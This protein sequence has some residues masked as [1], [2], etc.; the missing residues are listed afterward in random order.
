MKHY[1]V[2]KFDSKKRNADGTY[3]DQQEWTC[4]G[5]I[6]KKCGSMVLTP[7]V[8]LRTEAAYVNAVLRSFEASGLPHLRVTNL[9]MRHT[10]D[11]LAEQEAEFPFLDTANLASLDFVE[12][13]TVGPD[14]IALLV[15]QN[16]R[17]T[18]G[19][20]LEFEGNFFVHFG[21]DYYMYIGCT[22]NDEMA[23]AETEHDGLFVEEFISP[24]ARPTG[25][26]IPMKIEV[27]DRSVDF[28]LIDG[29]PQ[30]YVGSELLIPID[31]WRQVRAAFGYSE[32]HP[33]FGFYHVNAKV[34]QNLIEGFDLPLDLEGCE[35]TVNT[36][37]I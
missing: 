15:V 30:Y 12:D 17:G 34:G 18:L 36:T 2:T 23:R 5:E 9:S 4:I 33:F 19:C 21:W 7:Q 28:D 35:L 10:C 27:S 32:E 8:Y 20:K 1:R 13:Q 11:E 14:E 22:G 26:N 6:G 24:H 16:L 3:M 37:G 25:E 29:E 31:D